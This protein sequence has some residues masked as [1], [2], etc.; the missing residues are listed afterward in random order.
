MLRLGGKDSRSILSPLIDFGEVGEAPPV[1]G[2]EQTEEEGRPARPPL[3]GKYEINSRQQEKKRSTDSYSVRDQ[4]CA[5]V[6]GLPERN[7]SRAGGDGHRVAFEQLDQATE[8][9]CADEEWA[10]WFHHPGSGRI[11]GTRE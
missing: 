7:E 6:V 11:A 9:Y 2:K 8:D 4:E 10:E 5:S 1:K 3:F